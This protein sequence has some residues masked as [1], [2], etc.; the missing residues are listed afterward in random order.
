MD[1]TD[2]K[3]LIVHV[4]IKSMKYGPYHSDRGGG[5]VKLPVERQASQL[6][7]QLQVDGAVFMSRQGNMALALGLSITS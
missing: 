7:L 5:A 3:Y 2:N 4:S 1:L 6:T